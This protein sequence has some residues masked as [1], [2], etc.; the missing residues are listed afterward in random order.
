MP[1]IPDTAR[2]VI[3]GGGA[4]GAS[5]LYHLACS[6]WSDAVLIERDE[7]TSGSTWHAAG[8]C[9]T[10]SASWSIMNMQRYS[11]QIYRGLGEEVGYPINYHVTG[12]IRLAHSRQRMQEFCIAAGM[13]AAQGME[14][15]IIDPAEIKPRYPFIELHDLAGA[16]FDPCDGDI[17]P[18][19]LTQAFAKGARDRGA[20]VLR[21]NPVTGIDRKNGEWIIQT[22]AGRIACEFVVNA[23]GFGAANVGKM[24]LKHGGRE[25]PM[26]VMGHQYLLTEPIPQLEEWSRQEGRK[27]PLLRDVDTSYYLRQEKHGFNLGPYERTCQAYWLDGAPDDFSFQ[28]FPDDL[29]RIEWHVADAAARVPL[30]ETAGIAKIINGPIPYTPDGMPLIGPMPGVPNAF[31]ACVFSFGIAQAGG[32][33]KVL[34]EWVTNGETEWDMWSCDP[35]R[36]T[37]HADSRYCVAKA[38]ECYGHEYAIHFPHYSW[39]AGRDRKLSSAHRRVVERGGQMNAVNGWERAEWFAAAGDDTS[40]DSTRIF[41][42][43][44]PWEPRVQAECEAVRDDV[45]VLDLPGFSRFLLSG[46]GAA[47]ALNSLISGSLPQIGRIGLGYFPESR[48]RVLTEMSIIR[49]DTDSFTLI[50]AGAAQWH[51]REVLQRA[52]PDAAGFDIHDQTDDYATFLV[53]GP[54]SRQLLSSLTEADL[55]RPWLTHQPATVA[56]HPA[57]LVR[58]SFAGELGWEIHL[59]N[60]YG[61]SVYDAVLEAGA[62]PFGMVALDALRTEKAYRSW[63]GD[64]ST[65]YSLLECRLDR[66]VDLSKDAEFPGRKALI[67]ERKAGS[68]K[69]FSILDIDCDLYEAPYMSNVLCDGEI[70]GEVTSCSWGYR[71]SK[72]LALSM[73][74]SEYAAPGSALEVEIFGKRYAARVLPPEAPWDPQNLRLKA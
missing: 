16:L 62:W 33:G 2:V 69:L 17:D 70:I 6:G 44:G 29:D 64:L 10:F 48:G 25:V 55:A 23:A 26:A 60:D 8:N 49:H 65:D 54:R 37:A 1:E 57:H 36:F 42:R 58:V 61:A 18:A 28:L 34:T 52:R 39:P 71:V 72:C 56:G 46:P 9:P 22:P 19:Q 32:A 15:E 21:H 74:K 51:D 14:I 3:I 50:T 66:F 20:T 30:L 73:L 43:C 68:R 31:E 11:A 47:D 40:P 35:R 24:F 5:A 63:K 53:T 67:E 27:L 59:L 13:G 12:S 7:L 4:V 41:E 38:K 45:G